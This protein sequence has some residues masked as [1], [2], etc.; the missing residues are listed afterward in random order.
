MTK[1]RRAT[2]LSRDFSEIVQVQVMHTAEQI[3]VLL[4]RMDEVT[5][6]LSMIP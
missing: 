5:S 6:R 2:V 3:P 4:G 1:T